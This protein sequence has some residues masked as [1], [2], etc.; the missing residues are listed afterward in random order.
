MS[1]KRGP[2]PWFPLIAVP[3]I[4]ILIEAID[5]ITHSDVDAA[6]ATIVIL[7]AYIAWWFWHHR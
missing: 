6:I 2:F 3:V 4:V 7:G 5:R 1:E